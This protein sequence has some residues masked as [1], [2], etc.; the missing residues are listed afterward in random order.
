MNM[1][2]DIL[3][4]NS[5]VSIPDTTPPLFD[6]HLATEKSANFGIDLYIATKDQLVA[7]RRSMP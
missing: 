6:V 5:E 7:F 2:M 3:Q 1:Q 4:E